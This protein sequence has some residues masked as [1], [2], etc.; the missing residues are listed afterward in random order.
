[1]RVKDFERRD[2]YDQHTP[3]S[4]AR[5][6]GRPVVDN[7]ERMRRL[8][9]KRLSGEYGLSAT[10]YPADVTRAIGWPGLILITQN[11]PHTLYHPQGREG[12]SEPSTVKLDRT[13]L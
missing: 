11:V 13:N 9:Y 7:L 2:A 6:I 10:V 4:T 3:A 8:Q 12:I 1:M 5:G